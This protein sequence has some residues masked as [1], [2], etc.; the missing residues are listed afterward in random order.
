MK[1]FMKTLFGNGVIIPLVG[2]IVSTVVSYTVGK[3]LKEH[4]EK[5]LEAKKLNNNNE[6]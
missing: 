3:A 4:D 1:N 5:L 6:D 2:A